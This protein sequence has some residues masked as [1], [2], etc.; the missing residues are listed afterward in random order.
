MGKAHN[1]G[2]RKD[3]KLPSLKKGASSSNPDRL[4]STKAKRSGGSLREKAAIK[5]LKMYQGGRVKRDKQ[6]TVIQGDLACRSKSGNDDI[7]GATGRRRCRLGARRG[8][9]IRTAL[10]RRASRQSPRRPRAARPPL[11]RQHAHHRAHGAGYI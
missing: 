5:R 6:G 1:G 10:P 4:A 8:P 3:K 11:V 7:T 9:A 2:G